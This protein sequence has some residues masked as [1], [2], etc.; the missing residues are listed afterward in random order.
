MKQYC[1]HPDIIWCTYY[2]SATAIANNCNITLTDDDLKAIGV[3]MKRYR[4]PWMKWYPMV[5]A[6]KIVIDYIKTVYNKTVYVKE[7]NIKEYTGNELIVFS[8]KINTW[9]VFDIKDGTLNTALPTTWE[10]HARCLYKDTDWIWHI[11][12]NFL[13]IL[14]YNIITVWK[15]L[16]QWLNSLGYVY[17]TK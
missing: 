1:Q 4:M 7:I 16:P 8:G 2:A 14:P 11:V 3:I 10:G 12:E 5:L 6:R 13:W 9:Y 15:E 17:Y